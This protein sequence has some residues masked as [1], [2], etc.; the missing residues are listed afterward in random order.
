MSLGT[1]S[2]RRIWPYGHLMSKIKVFPDFGGLG[3]L[4]HFNPIYIYSYRPCLGVSGWG[5]YASTY[6]ACVQAYIRRP[7][8]GHQAEEVSFS[9][10]QVCILQSVQSDKFASLQ[11]RMCT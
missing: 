6:L 1:F 8:A 3:I 4:P 10:L 2:M 11:L 9:I 7:L 5:H